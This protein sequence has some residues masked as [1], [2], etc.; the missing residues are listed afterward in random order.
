MDSRPVPPQY[1]K[2]GGDYLEALRELG[3]NPNFLGWGWETAAEQWLLVLVTSIID[4]GGP[5][6]LNRLLFQAYNA[7]ATPKEISPFIVRVFSTEIIPNDFYMLGEKNLRIDT[8]NGK[9]RQMP[10]IQNI[11]RTFLGVDL[12]M[13]NSYQNLPIKKLKYHERRNAWNRFKHNVEKLAA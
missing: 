13:V 6:A 12:E 1:L 5:L 8:V 3:L 7:E 2:A 11:Q 9:K 4:A 10:A